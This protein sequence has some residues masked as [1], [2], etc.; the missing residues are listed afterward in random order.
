MASE[1]RTLWRRIIMAVIIIDIEKH[2][3][4]SGEC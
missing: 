4:I 2:S 3:C 1:V